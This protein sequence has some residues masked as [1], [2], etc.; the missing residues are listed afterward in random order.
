MMPEKQNFQ[1]KALH[2]QMAFLN[3]FQ[4]YTLFYIP[5]KNAEELQFSSF[6][7]ELNNFYSLLYSTKQV[8]KEENEFALLE[9]IKQQI[10]VKILEINA[11]INAYFENEHSI[12]E[13]L[14][15]KI[16]QFASQ[17]KKE[18]DALALI[19]LFSLYQLMQQLKTPEFAF[20]FKPYSSIIQSLSTCARGSLLNTAKE[21]KRQ[22]R[23]WCIA[24]SL[25]IASG[26]LLL[27]LSIFLMT[28]HPLACQV[29][30]IVLAVASAL[31][32]CGTSGYW[33]TK[34]FMLYSQDA[35]TSYSF[36]DEDGKDISRADY[37]TRIQPW[38]S[39]K[40]KLHG[41]FQRQEFAKQEQD[42]ADNLIDALQQ[43]NA[44]IDYAA[45]FAAK[46]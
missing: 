42:F 26:L 38:D 29:A 21:I 37:L 28:L 14:K 16:K 36:P 45:C 39:S 22:E 35:L 9:Q 40:L 8:R 30:G 27:G 17:Q 41:M 10:P 13:D 12:N 24:A 15:L 2:S 1:P 20:R 5:S 32:L 18:N 25:I 3:N 7:S 34:P 23:N 44:N 46:N 19:R 43:E 4:R 6:V 33:S 11:K 31:V